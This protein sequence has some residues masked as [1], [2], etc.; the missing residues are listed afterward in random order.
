MMKPLHSAAYRRSLVVQVLGS[1]LFNTVI[2]VLITILIPERTGTFAMNWVFS[3]CIGLSIMSCIEVPR[4]LLW[5]D[6]RRPHT[7]GLAAVIIAGLAIGLVVGAELGARI[8][9]AWTGWHIV[10]PVV[11]GE[12]LATS[13]IS[14][15]MAATLVGSMILASRA[16]MAALDMQL[17]QANA[18]AERNQRLL[19]QASEQAERAQ[20]AATEA[21]LQMLQAQ[22]EPH[23]LFNTLANLRVL[24]G[25]DPAAAQSM[26]DTLIRF[27]R[28]TLAASRSPTRPL[29]DD[30]AALQDYIALMQIRMGERLR[31]DFDLPAD[32]AAL[33]I[34]SMLLQPLVENA[35]KHGLEPQIA[36]GHLQVRAQ[37]VRSDHG[38]QL[39]L[40]V[41]DDGSGCDPQRVGAGYGTRHIAER[42]ATRYGDNVQ[43]RQVPVNAGCCFQIDLPLDKLHADAGASQATPS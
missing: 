14:I 18:D 38:P 7:L 40:T 2:A 3:Q 34:P 32:L 36:G 17:A 15:S 28:A 4:R 35:I 43:L 11:A 26:L 6:N 37:T 23:M 19:A 22:L 12:G 30:F 1:L 8:L 31:A 33:P 41:Q 13:V 10:N 25:L 29:A 24:I 39:R 9:S 5:P 20:R 42:L 16:R 21:Q 27:F